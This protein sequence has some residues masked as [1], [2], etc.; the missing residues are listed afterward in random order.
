[1]RRTLTQVARTLFAERGYVAT[2]TEDVVRAANVTRGALYHHFRDKR[3][4]FEA[5]FIEVEGELDRAV[6]ERAVRE[7]DAWA[8]FVAACSGYFDL[9]T[10][11][12]V[13]QI[14]LHDGPSVLGWERW[15]ELDMQY[16]IRSVQFGLDTLIALGQ[17]ERQETAP[18]ATLLVGALNEA[19]LVIAHSPD[20]AA[21]KAELLG[22][23]ERLIGGLRVEPA[24]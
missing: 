12:D 5:V 10:Q 6:R 17:I 8:A 2:G 23:F 4:L 22:S 24:T 15:R 1:M 16:S 20:R 13:A 7:T 3:E 19:G 14:V 9:A 11:D 18:L 21:A